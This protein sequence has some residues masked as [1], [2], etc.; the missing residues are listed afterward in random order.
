MAR[1]LSGWL[2]G[3]RTATTADDIAKSDGKT[4]DRVQGIHGVP[5]ESGELEIGGTYVYD[6]GTYTGT[7]QLKRREARALDP[8]DFGCPWDGVGDDLPGLQALIASIPSTQVRPVRI[9]LPAGQGYCSGNLRVNRPVEIVGHGKS[10]AGTTTTQNGIRFAPMCGLIFDGYYTSEDYPGGRSDH[11]RLRNLSITSTQAVA[12]DAVGNWG[13]AMYQLSTGED[14]WSALPATV[15]KGS[16]VLKSGATIGSNPAEYYGDGTTRDTTHPVMFRCTTSGTKGS[17]EPAAFATA[18]LGD[19]G[20]TITATG[21]TAVWTVEALPK[22]YT[23]E[24]AYV[25]GERAF[26]PGDPD[27]VFEVEVA[28]TSKGWSTTIAVASNGAALPQ[29]TIN[30]ASAANFP[31]AGTARVF[32]DAGAQTVTYTGTT[33]TTLTGC[34]GGTGRMSTGGAVTAPFNFPNHGIAARIPTGMAAPSFADVFYDRS[35]TITAGSDGVALPTGTIN[36]TDTNDLA[37]AGTVQIWTGSAYTAV[38]YTG[39]TSTTL[40]GCTGGTGTLSTGAEVGQG[41]RWKHVPGAEGITILGNW[42]NLEGLHIAGSTGAAVWVTGNYKRA[43]SGAGGSNFWALRDCVMNACGGGLTLNSNNANGGESKHCQQLF[44]GAGHTDVDLADYLNEADL[45]FGNGGAAVKDRCQ[46]NNRH[47]DHYMQFSGGLPFRNDLF[48][49]SLTT[50]NSTVWDKLAAE[51]NYESEILYPA[52]VI[53]APYGVTLRSTAT[54]LGATS[55]NIRTTAPL[56]SNPTKSINAVFGPQNL[57][58]VSAFTIAHSD[59]SY[60]VGLCLTDDIDAA[61]PSKWWSFG[62]A[63]LGGFDEQVFLFPRFAPSGATWPSGAAVSGSP[64][65]INQDRIWLGFARNADPPS[66]G[67]GTAAPASGYYVQ[68]SVVWNKNATVG[69]PNG[70][71]CTVTGS[72]GTWV[73]MANL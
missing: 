47:S 64:M 56:V 18:D 21:G 69:Q 3:L 48:V 31:S 33:G 65:W 1:D 73:A 50:G 66:I 14:L 36:V 41:V 4:I 32:T 38:A 67:F 45:R 26:V 59:D 6:P 29:A 28:G 2:P 8:R 42:V 30:V 63:N 70:W 52:V 51:S 58:A 22:D 24:H 44:I 54:I 60:A 62:K 7:T 37:V 68:G 27:H 9:Q 13:R 57:G 61:Y 35:T 20:T 55:K 71:R 49:G 40:T 23:N 25:V 43:V 53:E 16:C 19:L 46:G 12:S 17:A 72:P 11:S 15:A 10:Y 34:T 39:K 5:V